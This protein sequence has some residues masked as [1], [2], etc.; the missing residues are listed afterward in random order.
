MAPQPLPLPK[1]EVSG[2]SVQGQSFS[3][4]LKEKLQEVNTLQAEADTL[5]QKL[6]VGEPVDLHQ[7]M[8]AA[9]QANLALQLTVQIRN[10]IIEAYQEI[11][12]MQ[13]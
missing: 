8:I 1:A 2:Q 9:E 13:I 10:K 11:S 6:V 12:R 7:V 3:D 4:L 5:A